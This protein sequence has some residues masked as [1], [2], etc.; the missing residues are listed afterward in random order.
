MACSSVCF[1]D[2]LAVKLGE[3]FVGDRPRRGG[4]VAADGVQPD[5]ESHLAAAFLGEFAYPLDLGGR[6]LRRLTP[7]EIDVDVLGG[8]RKGG[9]RRT[10]EIDLRQ[11]I[12]R[13]GHPRV[14][15]GV[16]LA[17]EV[18]RLLAPHRVH[19]V[20]ELAGA[21][22]ALVVV[23]PVAEPTLLDV[24]AAGDDVQQHPALGEPLQ[25]RGLLGG[26]RRRYQ[27]GPEGDEELQPLGLGQQRRR[28]QPRVLAPGSG[29]A[30]ARLRSRAD[31]P[32]GPSPPGTGASARGSWRHG[33]MRRRVRRADDRAAVT[34]GGQEPVEFG[35]AALAIHS[36]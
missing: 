29:R 7:G 13:R 35:G 4:G 1:R 17:L 22:V 23:Q 28:G 26:Q 31:R 9:G 24:V 3:Q 15:D 36:S 20:Q 21:G 19:D 25:R 34:V 5:P 10:A 12:R 32:R 11:R 18:H 27:S 30:S 6:G 8:D 16:V 14:L 33:V 2:L